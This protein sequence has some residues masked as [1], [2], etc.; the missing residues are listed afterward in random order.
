MPDL[1]VGLRH[2]VLRSGAGSGAKRGRRPG[3]R[4]GI[5]RPDLPAGGGRGLSRRGRLT[6]A[7]AAAH[8]S[9]SMMQSTLCVSG[10]VTTSA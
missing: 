9:R 6:A 7:A 4:D 2:P 1:R 5:I 3:R 10:S 8:G